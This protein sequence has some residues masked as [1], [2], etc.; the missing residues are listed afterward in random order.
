MANDPRI[1]PRLPTGVP[2]APTAEQ[3]RA[4]SPDERER[5]LIEILDALSDPR[6]AMAEGRPHKKAKGR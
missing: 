4:M 3:W 2:V 1:Q 5:L 6:G